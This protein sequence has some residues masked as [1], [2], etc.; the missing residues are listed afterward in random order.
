MF[1]WLRN[2]NVARQVYSNI[3]NS[4]FRKINVTISIDNSTNF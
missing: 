3:I 1:T 2:P 4:E